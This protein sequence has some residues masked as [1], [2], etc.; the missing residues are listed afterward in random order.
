MSRR[1]RTKPA[2]RL[3]RSLNSF[4][5]A[6][7]LLTSPESPKVPL[8]PRYIRGLNF[9][10]SV[11]SKKPNRGY[12]MGTPVQDVCFSSRR[13]SSE[14]LRTQLH[15]QV[16]GRLWQLPQSFKNFPILGL[17]TYLILLAL[18][19]KHDVNGRRNGLMRASSPAIQHQDIL[20]WSQ[21]A[22]YRV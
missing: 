15:N 16:F 17:A 19:P 21:A 13:V 20:L 18:C 1:L 4:A 10:S 22:E 3:T 7:N 5:S 8:L 6:L 14:S 12:T 11:R 9:E 2:N